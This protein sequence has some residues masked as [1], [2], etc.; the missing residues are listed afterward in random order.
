MAIPMQAM[1]AENTSLFDLISS[2][3]DGEKTRHISGQIRMKI[4]FT[5]VLTNDAGIV[6]ELRGTPID[7]DGYVLICVDVSEHHALVLEHARL[8]I[9]AEA[10]IERMPQGVSVF[11]ENLKLQLWNQRLLDIQ[12]FECKHVYRG[13]NLV[14]MLTVLAR[15]GEY[16]PGDVAELVKLR[17]KLALKFEEHQFERTRMDGQTNL[18]QGY[19]ILSGDKIMG[20]ITIYTNITERKRQ[21]LEL[22]N[23]NSLVEK[24]KDE[25][26]RELQRAY[27]VLIQSE[28]LASLG[29]LVAGVAH[30][31][32]TPIG[33]GLTA[34]STLAF[35]VGEFKPMVNCG[36]KRSDLNK[37]IEEVCLGTDLIERNL[38]RAATLI[39]SF[40]QVAVDQTSAQ[41]RNFKLTDVITEIMYTLS[42]ILNKTPYI[43]KKDI[44]KHIQMDSFPG[45]LGQII[46]NLINNA[47]LHGFDGRNAGVITITAYDLGNGSITLSV[48]DDGIGIPKENLHHIYDPFFTTKMGR[49]GSGLGL[50]IAYNLISGLLGGAMQVH[51][52]L[53]LG[54]RFTMTLPLCAPDIN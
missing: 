39:T 27:G 25:R 47:M 48:A 30:E 12:G 31:L 52:T 33:I 35:R 2:V 17:H 46:I 51:S 6:L 10:A 36:M 13:A 20:F 7:H 19:P 21:E 24:N 49:G 1:L 41:R 22:S 28:K 44:P 3:F 26:T 40:K 38:A 50:S 23:L 14:D 15:R 32:N 53:G 45:P 4:E 37:F 54:T 34:S 11:D 9:F 29:A 8:L 42:P 16:G 18:I 5:E 43:V